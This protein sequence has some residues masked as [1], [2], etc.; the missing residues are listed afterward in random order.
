MAELEGDDDFLEELGN[1]FRFLSFRVHEG[2][3]VVVLHDDRA[4]VQAPKFDEG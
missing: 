1:E 4:E 3:C 2:D